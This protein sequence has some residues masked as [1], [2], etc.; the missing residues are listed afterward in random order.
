MKKFLLSLVALLA[1]F[2]GSSWA[3]DVTLAGVTNGS[4][5]TVNGKDGIKVG[6][7]KAD[8]AMTIT[9][10]AYTTKLTLH[11]AAWNG[12]NG[13]SVEIT[14]ATASPASLTLNPNTGISGSSTDYTLSEGS[15]EDAYKFEVALSNVTSET[16]LTLSASKRFVVWDASAETATVIQ[17]GKA[18]GTY[19]KADGS[20]P[21]YEGNDIWAAMWVSTQEDPQLTLTASSG[22]NASNGMHFG[23]DG[24]TYTLTVSDGYAI[25]AYALTA[26]AFG[27]EGSSTLTPEGGEGQPF[28]VGTPNGASGL[29]AQTVTFTISVGR[30]AISNFEVVVVKVPAAP[31][32]AAPVFDPAGGKFIGSQLVTIT[33][34]EGAAIY[35]TTDGTTPTAKSAR[36]TPFT[37]S[38]TTTVKAIA[39]KDEAVSDV[40]EATFTIVPAYSTIA[41]LNALANNATFG[42]TGEALVVAKPTAKYV[43]IHD[44]SGNSLIYDASGEK[45]AAV[46][47]GR[48]INPNWTGKVS[49]YKNLFELV[50]DEALTMGVS[51]YPISYPDFSTREINKVVSLK[52]VESYTVNGTS[53][54]INVKGAD[55]SFEESY[56]LA[57]YNQFGLEDAVSEEGKLYEII[58]VVGKYED[59]DQFWAIS[60]TEQ[61][62]EPI[63]PEPDPDF[64]VVGNMTDWLIDEAN[65]MTLNEELEKK[66]I[67]E[68]SLDM[69]LAANDEFKVVS[70]TD[71]SNIKEWFPAEG[72]NY[73]VTE[74]GEYTI[75]FRPNLDGDETW[76]EKCLKAEKKAAPVEVLE[77]QK[78]V[79]KNVVSNLYWGTG[80]GWDTQASLVKHPVYVKLDPRE[81][82]DGQYKMETQ[83]SNGG[84][85]YYFNG[86]YMDTN[87]PV[88]LT[89][90]KL[91]NGY[92]TIAAGDNYFG[93]DGTS[94]VLGKNLAADSKNALWEIVSLIDARAAVTNGTLE[95]PVD[96]TVLIE[97]YNFN[98]NNRYKDRWTG[99]WTQDNHDGNNVGENYMAA[100]SCL[101]TIENVPNGVYKLDAQAAV[102]FHDDRAVKAYDG[103]EWPV[104]FANEETSNF[105]ETTGSDVLSNQATM[106]NSFNA[107]NYQVDPVF[108]KV[109]DGTLKIGVKS[110][111][112]DIWVTWDNFVLTYYGDVDINEVKFTALVA[113]L[114][115]A[116]AT[117]KS[118]DGE[119]PATAKSDYSTLI[120]NAESAEYNT[121]EDYETAIEGLN[122]GYA[123]AKALS[124]DYVAFVALKT[125]AQAVIDGTEGGS[126]EATALANALTDQAAAVE[127]VALNGTI[128]EATSALVSACK[129]YISTIASVTKDID[130]IDV[131]SFVITNPN[132]MTID[133]WEGTEFG[134]VSNGVCEYWNKSA[135]DFHQTI[136]L[137]A[138]D[139]K[140]TAVALQRTGMNGV[141]YA[142]ENKTTIAGVANSVV[143]NEAQ[144]AK[145]FADGNGKN[146][147]NFTMAEAGNITI[148]LTA[149]NST[150]DHWT[151]WQSFKLEI[152]A[153]VTTYAINIAETENG[154][155]EA[156]I[157]DAVVTEAA[158]GATVTLVATPAEGYELESYYVCGTEADGIVRVGED[159]SF[160]MPDFNVTVSAT[161]KEKAAEPEKEVIVKM[162]YVSNESEEG[163]ADK[164]FGEV[165][166]AKA[167]YNKITNGEVGFANTAWARN[168]ITYIQADAS[169]FAGVVKKATM[170]AEVSGTIDANKRVAV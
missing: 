139:F 28:V 160:V 110:E 98:R 113:E 16:T 115:E 45:T 11:A 21:T 3:A 166:V 164:A 152:V 82:P 23:K 158:A 94:T 40:A 38:E 128:A 109:T 72:D 91:E 19:Y 150:P 62:D 118:F 59:K 14:G 78:Y 88:T 89:V 31:A 69:T 25:I 70:S 84:T 151:V 27:A 86:D 24:V 51:T 42:F 119:L 126:E 132:P 137:P 41:E 147:V 130:D 114:N 17:V 106:G 37:V 138:G 90:T 153:P 79:I 54:T 29:S 108:V 145:W 154:T 66:G 5:C 53:I 57:G 125:N 143:N 55:K 77:Y 168:Y 129:A 26:S 97:D 75:Y 87:A 7:S 74:A 46:E 144:A 121:A 165:E 100:A 127:A 9:V 140:L 44:N 148:G 161:F 48:F 146:V 65:K 149:D 83:V 162:T 50:P 2:V 12:V 35:Y 163:D 112:S 49:I 81:M 8:G 141:I 22:I 122:A 36:Y 18:T 52:N 101:Q 71:G 15:D 157:A 1:I 99:T 134:T 96:A 76:H 95:A 20:I 104:V 39:I 124:A 92:Y 73:E 80:N 170:T 123:S 61:N 63:V 4:A 64:Y 120:T 105:I 67:K 111:R 32:V 93:W 156:K 6:T 85:S 136:S 33:C 116:I 133:G 60:I 155:V 169:A 159:G 56:G 13:L 43:Y 167:G 30:V 117:A 107:G 10:P 34:E 47:A 58:G 102:T 135:A 68:F 131:T 103:G 142:G